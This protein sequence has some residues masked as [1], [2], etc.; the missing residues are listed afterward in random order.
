MTR[1][2]DHPQFA[3]PHDLNPPRPP[4]QAHSAPVAPNALAELAEMISHPPR[5]PK[6]GTM[7]AE[8]AMRGFDTAATD[9]EKLGKEAYE[10]GSELLQQ[11]ITYAKVLRE[12]GEELCRRIEAETARNYQISTIMRST[13]E[14]MAGIEAEAANA[15]RPP[16]I[17]ET[18]ARPPGPGLNGVQKG[19]GQQ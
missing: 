10:R 2:I 9:I 4:Q 8:T 11:S 14:R 3:P 7:S 16:L 13:Q 17:P 18:A 15:P 12:A 5:V 19:L 6:L 1:G